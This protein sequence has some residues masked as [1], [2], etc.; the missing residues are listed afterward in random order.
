MEESQLKQRIVGAIVLVALAVIFIPMFLTGRSDETGA[1]L[2]TNIPPQPIEQKEIRVLQLDKL[3]GPPAQ[4]PAERSLV[5]K[6]IPAPPPVVP[7]TQPA[8]HAAPPSPANATV[9]TPGKPTAKVE[10]AKAESPAQLESTATEAP[11]AWAVQ[12]GSFSKQANALAL[13]DKLRAKHY[14]AFVDAVANG[15]SRVF[16]VRVGPAV[17]RENAEELQKR[18]EKDLKLKGIVVAHP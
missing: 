9:T 5:D 11:K 18:I 10:T 7:G 16:R 17:R 2:G 6:D 12:V 3:P 14:P 4:D 8:T 1:A 15:G 13:R